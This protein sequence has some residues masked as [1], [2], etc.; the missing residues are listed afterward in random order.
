MAHGVALDTGAIEDNQP[1]WIYGSA[2]GLQVW[3]V[4][5]DPAVRATL[6]IDGYARSGPI[7]LLNDALVGTRDE[8]T[9]LTWALGL[10]SDGAP[11]FYVLRCDHAAP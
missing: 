9:S 2:R 8:G 10:V 5:L 4:A 11:G 1:R 6:M 3:T 7:M